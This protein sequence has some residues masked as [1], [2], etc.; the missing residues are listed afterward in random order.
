MLDCLFLSLCV[1]LSVAV[2]VVV[3]A[4]VAVAALAVVCLRQC[5]KTSRPTKNNLFFVSYSFVR[6]VQ[7]SVR[8]LL[9]VS[10]HTTK[11]L[12]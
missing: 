3:G 10:Q 8:K 11:S 6:F 2:V 9:S 12:M 1:G 5:V 7:I 4:V